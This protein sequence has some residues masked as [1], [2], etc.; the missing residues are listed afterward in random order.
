MNP[1]AEFEL[2]GTR[3]CFIVDNHHLSPLYGLTFGIPEKVV[4][5]KIRPC[6]HDLD[7]GNPSDGKDLAHQDASIP[8]LIKATKELGLP[9]LVFGTMSQ[10]FG[11]MANALP[12]G[13]E[14]TL[15]WEAA[16][17][18]GL[19]K[20]VYNHVH[21]SWLVWQYREHRPKVDHDVQPMMEKDKELRK[22]VTTGQQLLAAV[23]DRYNSWKSNFTPGIKAAP[24]ML[25]EAYRIHRAFKA[26]HPSVP[27]DE[28][29]YIGAYDIENPGGKPAPWINCFKLEIMRKRGKPY[30]LPELGDGS[31]N[32][33]LT[34]W[35]KHIQPLLVETG[36]ANKMREGRYEI[37]IIGDKD[38]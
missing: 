16:R 21:W 32:Q 20:D 22:F 18:G 6:L 1:C 12:V 24:R 27:K 28:T 11:G 26:G 25:A 14:P 34:L 19:W 5:R 29:L 30:K 37:A 4:T 8:G 13:Y 3:Y 31:E 2:F 35:R 33:E 23:M 7:F 17:Q 9:P 38:L 15:G 36:E 10:L